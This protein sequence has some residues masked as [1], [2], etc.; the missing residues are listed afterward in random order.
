MKAAQARRLA[1]NVSSGKVKAKP[2]DTELDTILRYVG[3]EASVGCTF[4]WFDVDM[5]LD[6]ATTSAL[7]KL[8]YSVEYVQMRPTARPKWRVC[9]DG[10]KVT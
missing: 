3:Y 1:K 10:K 7:E 8:G 6:E 2:R 4:A 5:L 9:W